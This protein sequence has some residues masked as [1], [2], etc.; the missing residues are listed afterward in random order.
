[1]AI[2]RE[3]RK[4]TEGIRFEFDQAKSNFELIYL[5]TDI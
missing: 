3:T 1:M 2:E 5:L 4:I